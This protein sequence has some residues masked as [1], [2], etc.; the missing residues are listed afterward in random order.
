[1]TAFRAMLSASPRPRAGADE[2]AR[3]R[4]AIDEAPGEAA[5]NAARW[6][7]VLRVVPYLARLRAALAPGAEGTR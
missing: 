1:M 3:L 7:L 4:R 5:R 2:E 6:E